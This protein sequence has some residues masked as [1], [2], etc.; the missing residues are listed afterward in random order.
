[1]IAV[2][3]FK[4]GAHTL[5]LT[6]LFIGFPLSQLPTLTRQKEKL[7]RNASQHPPHWRLWLPGRHALGPSFLVDLPPFK[8]LYVLVRT[9]EQ[10][11]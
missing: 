1:M 2:F 11:A 5:P 10:T 4:A 6:D 3:R 9:E 7:H 8:K